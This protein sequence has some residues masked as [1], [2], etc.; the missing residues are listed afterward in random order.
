MAA[1]LTDI[2]GVIDHGLFLTEADEILVERDS[3]TIERR[4]RER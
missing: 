1:A 2:P 3:G 4:V